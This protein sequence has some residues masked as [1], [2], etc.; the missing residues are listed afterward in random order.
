M[1]RT[2]FKPAL[3]AGL[4]GAAL[5]PGTAGAAAFYIIE[6]S[7]S[8]MGRAFAG[9]SAVAADASTA[10][11]NPAAISRFDDSRISAAGH[12]IVPYA[13]FDNDGSSITNSASPLSGKNSETKKTALVPNFYY[14]HPLN[15]RWSLGF[16]LNAPFGLESSYEDDWFGRYHA[17]DSA[18]LTVN[19]NPTVAYRVNDQLSLGGGISYQYLD[20]T[21]S[22][23]VD[24]AAACSAAG[25]TDASC[26][27]KHGGFANESAD[28]EVEISGD[29][30]AWAL[31]L[32]LLYE[33]DAATR[34]GVAWR[35]GFDYTADGE[36]DFDR[37][38]SC[39]A[40]PFCSGA[41]QDADVEA[42]IEL[43]SILSVA[44]FHQLNDRWAIMGDV[45]WYQWSVLDEVP[46]ERK[47][48]GESLS[49]LELEY[50]DTFRYNIGARY[51]YDERWTF[52]GGLAFDEAPQ[53]D[54]EFVTPRIPDGDRTW[55]SV[56]FNYAVGDD[57][58]VDVGYSHLFVSAVDIDKV[59]QRA[60]LQ[61][62][63]DPTVDIFSVQTNWRF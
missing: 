25:D 16:A 48:D 53:T 47:S 34:I 58:D 22:N 24:S 43:P 42:S 14:T 8:G 4:V 45:T 55:L 7:G 1:T 28:S 41:T 31:N 46:I 35:Q 2:C 63:F 61:G 40:D 13:E 54:P 52:R 60:R 11:F 5:V 15:D 62:E 27:A 56:G 21:L 30:G 32:G 17:L 3:L 39:A 9:A 59:E 33:L 50:D 20:T 26:A 10:Y 44:A 36:A 29:A 49:T 38:S 12:L 23:A 51:R 19:V 57:F 6:S 37:S 18:L